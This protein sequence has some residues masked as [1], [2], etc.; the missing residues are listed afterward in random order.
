MENSHNHSRGLGV[1]SLKFN[2]TTSSVVV[3][4]VCHHDDHPTHRDCKYWQYLRQ[5]TPLEIINLSSQ[6]AGH[7][8]DTMQVTTG[9]SVT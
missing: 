8:C 2:R 3:V 9:S 5:D 6:S 1:L 4:L 7:H